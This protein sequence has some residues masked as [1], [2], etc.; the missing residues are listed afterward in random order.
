MQNFETIAFKAEDAELG[1]GGEGQNGAGEVEV[2][3]DEAG[4]AVVVVVAEVGDAVSGLIVGFLV[5]SGAFWLGFAAELI[6]GFRVWD[7]G[8]DRG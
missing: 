8:V 4:D 5:V 7:L 6:R 2:F 3:E 1:E